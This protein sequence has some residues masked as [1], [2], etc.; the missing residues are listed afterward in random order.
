MKKIIAGI[1]QIALIVVFHVAAYAQP[2]W[3]MQPVPIQT[4]WAKQVSPS[5]AL[6][7]Y[8]RPQMARSRWVNLNGLWDYAI[9]PRDAAPPAQYTGK[10]LVPYPLESALSGVRGRLL[11]DQQL[12]YRRTTQRP[13]LK[14]GQRVLLHF[15][16]VDWQATV[17]VNGKHVGEHKG[18]YQAFT[19]D[20]TNDLKS[21]DN[22][23][24]VAVYDP[25][26]KGP[27]PHGKQVLAPQHIMYT[28]SSGIWQT[29]WLEVVPAVHIESLK[30]TPDIEHGAERVQVGV[31]GDAQGYA[32]EITASSENSKITT[33]KGAP[34]KELQLAIAHPQLWSPADPFLDTLSV[35]LL[36]GSKA[37]DTVTSYFGMRKIEIKK[38]SAGVDRIFLNNHYI[39]NLGVLDQ[40]FWPDGLYTAPTDDALRFDIEAIKSMGFNTIRKHIK[41]EPERWYYWCDKLGILVWQD[42]P[43]PS[44]ATAEAKAEFEA[45]SA[46]NI[47]QLYN[48]P[49]IIAWVLFNEGW[50]A[51]DQERLAKWMKQLDPSR[52]LNGHTGGN[53]NTRR[54]E[55]DYAARWAASDMTD[56]HSYP[57]PK[58]PAAEPGKARVLGEYGGVGVL[59]AGHQ[60]DEASAWGYVKNSPADF[61]TKYEAMI[62]QLKKFEAEGLSGSIYTQPFDVETEQNGLLTYDRAMLKMPLDKMR[63]AN[64]TLAPEALSFAAI[65]AISALDSA[66]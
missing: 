51:Y 12:W 35:R 49:S 45:E 57:D 15:G 24:V 36:Q 3:R 39:Y 21:G 18:G 2:N 64:A 46:A 16:A 34:G 38:D 61:V 27:N 58:I 31:A 43:Q 63:Q 55:Q 42:M 66:R 13:A 56:I 52:L 33:I 19:F 11:P 1:A 41:I 50:G 59:V 8:P 7:E 53:V 5:N 62:A 14:G 32:V 60:W 30:L 40:G 4:R 25:T 10:I 44:N 22:E 37:I 23:L 20:I 48:H 29:V 47:Q 9:A 65:P 17:Y 6:P 54:S 28:A 26:D